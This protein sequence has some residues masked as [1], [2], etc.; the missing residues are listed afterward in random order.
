MSITVVSRNRYTFG[1]LI[2][3]LLMHAAVVL[4]V[5]V[6]LTPRLL[7][8][9]LAT[10]LI[11]MFGV[12]AGYH[13]YFSHRSYRLTRPSQLVMALLAQSSAQKG[14]LWW[15]AQHRSHHR[16][17]DGPAD[18]HSPV[19]RG[20]WWA[21]VGWII[22]NEH[23][24]YDPR[25][26][27]DFGKYAELRWLD[28]NHWVPTAILATSILA[29][30][31]WPAFFWGYIVS[32]VV[33]YHCTFSINSIGHLWGSRRF[34]TEDHSRN[35]ALLALFSLG[36]GWHNNH[37]RYPNRC[38][39]GLKWWEIDI[40]YRVLKMLSWAGIVRNIRELPVPE[41]N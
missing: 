33:L 15:S 23:E 5:L 30:G 6:P 25:L 32:T 26:V 38:R 19:Q 27:A 37:H 8:L 14:I 17:P 39:Q 34:E 40:T 4:V 31:G 18:P 2:P 24:S 11:R 28:R 1:L 22:S 13:R 41:A 16:Q 10:F 36:E 12:T 3:F 9:A 20:F 35:N 21:H 29:F 7:L